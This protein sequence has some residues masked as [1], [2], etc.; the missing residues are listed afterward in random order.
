MKMLKCF[1]GLRGPLVHPSMDPYVRPSARIYPSPTLDTPQPV[2]ERFFGP[3]IAPLPA[4]RQSL[5]WPE[6]RLKELA[7][8]TRA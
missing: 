7:L 3:G 5:Y 6:V 2:S 4:R 1:L 8:D